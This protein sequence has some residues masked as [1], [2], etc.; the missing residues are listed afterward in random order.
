[1]KTWYEALSTYR[2][3]TNTTGIAADHFRVGYR[4]GYNEAIF[5]IP[6]NPLHHFHYST[7]YGQGKADREKEYLRTML[8][9]A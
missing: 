9:E 1:M 2:H 4:D 5:T 3:A 8:T 6:D 7:G